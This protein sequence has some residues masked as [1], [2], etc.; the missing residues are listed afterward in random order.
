M[1]AAER[2]RAARAEGDVVHGALVP[3]TGSLVATGI[4]VVVVGPNAAEALRALLARGL[5]AAVDAPT[6]G[7]AAGWL[8]GR[9]AGT[10]TLAATLGGLLP[11]LL[12]TRGYFGRP[13]TEARRQEGRPA[14]WLALVGWLALMGVALYACGVVLQL[15]PAGALAVWSAS[16]ELGQ[17]CGLAVLAVLTTLVAFDHL[18]KRAARRARLGLDEAARGPRLVAP[19]ADPTPRWNELLAGARWVVFDS[20]RA[21]AIGM[22]DGQA[23]ITARVAAGQVEALCDAARARG[24]PPRLVV[25]LSDVDRLSADVALSNQ[26][27]ALWGISV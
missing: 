11:G 1:A 26:Q 25:D 24:L 16:R 20:R 4:A 2:D 23:F 15:H 14:L 22:R 3:V 7:A 12:Q 13:S 27:L 21:I 10:V 9:S 18:R 8:L 6:T 17:R 19:S 5:S